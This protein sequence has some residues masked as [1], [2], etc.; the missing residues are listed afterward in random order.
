MALWKRKGDDPVVLHSDRGTQFTS[1]D[2]QQFLVDHNVLCSMSAA[3]RCADNAAAE[4]S[5]ACS[6]ESGS[7]TIAEARQNV[8]DYI[9]RFHNPRV[10]GA[11]RQTTTQYP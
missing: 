4:D 6:S 3:G 9:E 5:S 2:Y 8:F 10:R 7:T 11:F 1:D